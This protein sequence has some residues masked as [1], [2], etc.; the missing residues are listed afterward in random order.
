MTVVVADTD[1]GRDL[2]EILTLLLSTG[3]EVDSV[4]VLPASP[5]PEKAPSRTTPVNRHVV[6]D[7]AGAHG[8]YV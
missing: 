2:V 4:T 1:G 3:L 7:N 8:W 6:T 5:S